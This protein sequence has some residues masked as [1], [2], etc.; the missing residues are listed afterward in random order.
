MEF[1]A[2]DI[3]HFTP[4]KRSADET[5]GLLSHQMA[6]LLVIGLF[7]VAS[8]PQM[9]D[10]LSDIIGDNPY[11]QIGAKALA[12]ALVAYFIIPKCE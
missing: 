7:V 12:F 9:N 3:E 4:N 5:G 6:W 8:L 10:L 11:V 2:D 1:N